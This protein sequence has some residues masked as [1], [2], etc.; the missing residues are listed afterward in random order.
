MD[1]AR[2]AAETEKL[3]AALLNSISHDLRTPLSTVLGAATTLIDFVQCVHERTVQ[4]SI[5]ETQAHWK[6]ACYCDYGFH[7]TLMGEV[8]LPHFGQL[9]DGRIYRPTQ[10]W[11]DPETDIAL[12]VASGTHPLLP[13]W[14]ALTLIVGSLLLAWKVEGR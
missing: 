11:T 9:A 3:R 14:L 2:I 8:P 10:T 4:E 1:R 6:D 13:A 7:L 5:A 12:D